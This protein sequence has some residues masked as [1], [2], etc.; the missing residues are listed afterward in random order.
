MSE[1]SSLNHSRFILALIAVV[2]SIGLRSFNLLLDPSFVQV[3][4][5]VTGLFI[6][7]DVGGAWASAF[8]TQ[9]VVPAVTTVDVSK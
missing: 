1:T 9:K 8:F 2:G 6:A 3:V 5:W 7:G 4:I